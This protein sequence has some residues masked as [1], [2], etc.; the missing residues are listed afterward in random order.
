MGAAGVPHAVNPTASATTV[1]SASVTLIAFR[2]D[3]DRVVVAGEAIDVSCPPRRGYC[4]N[5]L[6]SNY[7][8]ARQRPFG[9]S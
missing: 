6:R 4:A 7:V 3:A 8:D 2:R 1:T 5:I 9:A